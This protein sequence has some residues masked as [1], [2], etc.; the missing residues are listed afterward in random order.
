MIPQNACLDGAK[1]P[2]TSCHRQSE[3]AVTAPDRPPLQVLGPNRLTHRPEQQLSG[4]D[5]T[6][7]E[8]PCFILCRGYRQRHFPTG[9]QNTPGAE[10]AAKFMRLGTLSRCTRPG[11]EEAGRDRGGVTGREAEDN[12]ERVAQFGVCGFW[13]GFQRRAY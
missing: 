6:R 1:M 10:T 13:L 8:F 11:L 2:P 5:L 9:G 4:R 7:A 3:Q 12:C